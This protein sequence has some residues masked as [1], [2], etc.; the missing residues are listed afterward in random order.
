MQS[1]GAYVST[2]TWG[3]EGTIARILNHDTIVRP[4][5]EARWLWDDCACVFSQLPTAVF[6]TSHYDLCQQAQTGSL[7]AK[8]PLLTFVQTKWLDD[9]RG[10]EENTLEGKRNSSKKFL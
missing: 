5:K 8:V 2:E 1:S 7:I 4:R 3:I 9:W 10:I 6:P